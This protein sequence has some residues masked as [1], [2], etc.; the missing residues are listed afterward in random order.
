LPNVFAGVDFRQSPR[1]TSRRDCTVSA[2]PRGAA[3]RCLCLRRDDDSLDTS[4]F[5]TGPAQC[6]RS[7]S[8][9]L[10]VSSAR[11]TSRARRFY[12]RGALFCK[13]AA[14]LRLTQVRNGQLNPK[15]S[16]ESPTFSPSLRTA[17]LSVRTPRAPF[18]PQEK[19]RRERRIA[20]PLLIARLSGA[21]A[22]RRNWFS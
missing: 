22:R 9:S 21:R 7:V 11:S 4:S 8:T 5:A 15:Q 14:F 20:I 16:R 13:T 2:R 18:C 17:L 6:F 19:R 12:S 1:A 10:S 3:E